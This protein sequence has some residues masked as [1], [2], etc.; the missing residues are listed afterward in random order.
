M[1]IDMSGC[2]CIGIM[3]ARANSVRFPV[4]TPKKS[5]NGK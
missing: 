3:G 5:I 2:T 1:K 4:I